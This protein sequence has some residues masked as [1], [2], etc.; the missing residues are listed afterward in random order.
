MKIKFLVLNLFF[1]L[2]IYSLDCKDCHFTETELFMKTSHFKLN[3]TECHKNFEKHILNPTA[4][5]VPEV[6]IGSCMNCHS[7]FSGIK[8]HKRYSVDCLT[9][10]SLNHS[11]DVKVEKKNCLSCHNLESSKFSQ[12]FSHRLEC[13]ECHNPH[14]DEKFTPSFCTRCHIDKKGPF[15]YE[16]M[17]K[18]GGKCTLCHEAHGSPN[19]KLLKNPNVSFLCLE[20]HMDI[21]NFH[22]PSQAVYQNCILCHGE[23]HGSNKNKYFI[24]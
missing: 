12:T 22:N 23:I 21:S 14:R 24:D 16:H 5:N 4:F 7:N 2:F 13:K 11:K 6:N 9:C 10:H 1:S 18:R 15:V 20:C 17:P 3:C 19:P 8:K